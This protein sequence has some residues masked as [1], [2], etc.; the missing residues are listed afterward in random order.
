MTDPLDII[1]AIITRSELAMTP[2]AA[3]LRAAIYAELAAHDIPVHEIATRVRAAEALRLEGKAATQA[4]RW[5]ALQERVRAGK[6]PLEKIEAAKAILA[7]GSP[8]KAT[9]KQLDRLG[10]RPAPPLP[11]APPPQLAQRYG[12]PPTVETTDVDGSPLQTPRHR[13]SWPVDALAHAMTTTEYEAAQRLRWCHLAREGGSRVA[14]L[15]GGGV[16]VPGPRLPA[17]DEQVAA[18]S[19]WRDISHRVRGDARALLWNFALEIPAPGSRVLLDVVEFGRAYINIRDAN[20]A[21]GAVKGSLR[22]ALNELAHLWRD[23]DR[24]RQ[25]GGQMRAVAQDLLWDGRIGQ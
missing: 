14:D 23:I 1:A 7:K 2:S 18:A 19:D 4:Q 25:H 9:R 17:T 12:R 22:L 20:Q 16:C 24:A 21:R 13:F 5:R 8:E 3:V 11:S 15:Q 10:Q 6:L